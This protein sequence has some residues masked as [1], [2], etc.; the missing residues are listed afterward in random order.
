MCKE[1]LICDAIQ[2]CIWKVLSQ[3]TSVCKKSSARAWGRL[4]IPTALSPFTQEGLA[5]VR[6]VARTWYPVRGYPDSS[7]VLSLGQ[8]CS[9]RLTGYRV[10]PTDRAVASV[11]DADGA[12]G[13]SSV[14]QH[15]LLIFFLHT[16]VA[17][18]R[19]F[20]MQGCMASKMSHFFTHFLNVYYR[21]KSE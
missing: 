11:S 6:S 9:H 17:C 18:E 4:K 21:H 8:H 7:Q 12:Y 15:V 19:A 16:E 5:A 1:R 10:R 20:Q 2:A 14:L 13:T 3:V